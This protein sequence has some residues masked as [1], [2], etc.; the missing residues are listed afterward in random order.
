MESR[1][2]ALE[3][4]YE[5]LGKLHEGG[6]GAVYKVR[7]RLLD[8][9]R[10]VKVISE[11]S[12]RGISRRQLI[13]QSGLSDAPDIFEALREREPWNHWLIAPAQDPDSPHA[14]SP[15][16]CR[17]PPGRLGPHARVQRGA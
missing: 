9:L 15:G 10:V 7:H 13:S 2:P 17:G 11:A 6:M 8:Q 14:A 4:K 3:G 5:I 1:L 12:A 16:R